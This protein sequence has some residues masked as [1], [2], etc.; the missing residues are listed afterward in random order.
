MRFFLYRQHNLVLTLTQQTKEEYGD[1]NY[2]RYRGSCIGRP[3]RWCCILR[4]KSPFQGYHRQGGARRRDA[5]KGEGDL[6]LRMDVK[7][8]DEIG[9]I[10][11]DINT[12]VELSYIGLKLDM[13]QLSFDF[14]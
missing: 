10:A 7:T 13:E 3:R 4:S 2:H 14:I 8:N 9:Q 6:T 12:F 5:E 11:Q 1:Y